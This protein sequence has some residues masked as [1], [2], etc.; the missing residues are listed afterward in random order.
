MRTT[1]V[2]SATTAAVAALILLAG[3]AN[4]TTIPAE[5]AQVFFRC[6]AGYVFQTS[7]NNVR[8]F[9]AGSEVTATIVCPIGYV[10]TQDQFANNRD[11]CQ[12]TAGPPGAKINTLS[13]YT[14]PNGFTSRP[15]PGPDFCVRQTPPS[16]KAPNVETMI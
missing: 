8:C 6:Q 12:S 14:C 9:L 10:K 5:T 3:A 11:G 7:G 2:L 16:I 1:K 15:Q 13:N 4:P